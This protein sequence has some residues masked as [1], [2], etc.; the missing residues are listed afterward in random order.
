MLPITLRD[1]RREED[2]LVMLVEQYPQSIR[3]KRRLWNLQLKMV[4][5]AIECDKFYSTPSNI[6][7][8]F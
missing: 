5:K 7:T 4:K 3:L 1:M 6:R 2:K 8:E